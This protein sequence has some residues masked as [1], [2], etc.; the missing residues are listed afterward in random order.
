MTITFNQ[1]KEYVAKLDAHGH[2]HWRVPT[3][4]ACSWAN[5][6]LEDPFQAVVCLLETIGAPSGAV[7]GTGFGPGSP[8]KRAHCR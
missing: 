1:A 8:G 6:C 7:A 5:A 4:A 3:K 2:R